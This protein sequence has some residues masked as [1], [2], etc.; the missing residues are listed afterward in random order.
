M[1]KVQIS[2]G[3]VELTYTLEGN[4]NYSIQEIIDIICKK[5]GLHEAKFVIN[6]VYVN[7]DPNN[8]GD[9]EES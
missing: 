9:P 8:D 3:F 4:E 2:D 1:Y 6:S 7:P 5:T